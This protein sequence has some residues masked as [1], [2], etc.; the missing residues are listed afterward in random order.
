MSCFGGSFPQRRACS[1]SLIQVCLHFPTT[2]PTLRPSTLPQGRTRPPS[3]LSDFEREHR[4]PGHP[5][6]LLSGSNPS[7]ARESHHSE[8]HKPLP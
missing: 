6:G 2:T 7:R 4:P 3:R 5:H 8:D 1:K